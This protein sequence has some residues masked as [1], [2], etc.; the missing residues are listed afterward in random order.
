MEESVLKR[1]L[2]AKPKFNTAA[3]AVFA[4]LHAEML[5]VGFRCVGVGENGLPRGTNN[6]MKAHH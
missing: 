6:E 4:A 3:D 1:I 2:D 5:E